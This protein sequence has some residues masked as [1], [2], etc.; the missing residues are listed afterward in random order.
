VQFPSLV[1]AGIG[2]AFFL[3]ILHGLRDAQPVLCA[4]VHGTCY[5]FPV[6]QFTEV[7]ALLRVQIE[8][9]DMT[10]ARI[11]IEF[12]SDV[13]SA[14]SDAAM[15]FVLPPF[16]RLLIIRCVFFSFQNRSRNFTVRN[17]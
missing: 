17:L 8:L 2:F 4:T 1:A 7:W 16:K 12:V 3:V 10:N 14:L 15:Q 5:T 9:R 13:K 6:V 11:L